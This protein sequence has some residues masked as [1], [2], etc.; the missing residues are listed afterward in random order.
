LRLEQ[1]QYLQLCT[2]AMEKGLGVATH[3]IGDAA[4]EM[5]ISVYK[6]LHQSFPS[7]IKRIE[8]LGLPEK[9]HL[10]AMQENNIACSMQ[11]IF[12]D[13]LGKNFIKYLDESYL[14]HCYP[15][16][17]V[18]EHGILTALSSDAPVVK[19]FN[20]F[21]GTTAAV[22]RKNNEGA[23]IAAHESISAAQALKA[24][25]QSAAAISGENRY[26]TLEAGKLADFIIM[27]KNPLSIPVEEIN[28]IKVLQTFVDG[29]KVWNAD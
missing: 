23:L 25:T 21:K 22:T 26:G 14:D 3:A 16:K 28:S 11:T 19:N 17:S 12:L 8:H 13:E 27:D 5:V 2:A 10:V 24:Y 18:L 6:K 4:I 20:P 29:K 9:Q 15:V 7:L 1:K